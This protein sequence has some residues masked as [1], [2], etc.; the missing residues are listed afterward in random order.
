MTHDQIIE[1]LD[2]NPLAVF[3]ADTVLD[4]TI[5][6]KEMEI[7]LIKFRHAA[8]DLCSHYEGTFCTKPGSTEVMRS[9][10]NVRGLLK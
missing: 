9:W 5:A 2:R 10:D 1:T 4:L 3:S 6:Q 7:N 8:A